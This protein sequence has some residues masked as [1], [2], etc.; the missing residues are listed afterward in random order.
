MMGDL[1]VR[2]PTLPWVFSSF[3]QN[4][5][6]PTQPSLPIHPDVHQSDFFLF[7]QMKKVLKGKH[8]ANVEEVKQKTGETL[9]G[10]KMDEIKN[11]S[12]QWGK[13]SQ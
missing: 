7:P 6:W 13:M 12:E 10:V 5:A 8:F 11:C 4:T 9:R 3:D 2:L 1:Q